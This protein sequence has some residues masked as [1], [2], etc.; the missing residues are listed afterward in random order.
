MTI[1][2]ANEAQCEVF[3]Q[4]Y[5]KYDYLWKKDQQQALQEFLAAE[6]SKLP[7]GGRDDPPLAKFEEQINKYKYVQLDEMQVT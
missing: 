5:L 3:K 7:D 4:Q 6:G 2:L 1:V